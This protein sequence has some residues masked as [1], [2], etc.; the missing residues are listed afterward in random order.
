MKVKVDVFSQYGNNIFEI[1]S[2]LPDSELEIAEEIKLRSNIFFTILY[3]SM[4]S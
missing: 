3:P 1:E 4:K 2:H